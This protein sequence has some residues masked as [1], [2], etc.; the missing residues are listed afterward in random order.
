MT[1]APAQRYEFAPPPAPKR[2]S[3]WYASKIKP[4][5]AL[6][7]P[8]DA[9]RLTV[10]WVLAALSLC[11]LWFVFFATVMSSLQEAHNQHNAYA[12]FREQL[13]QL[14]PQTAP[15]G[16]IITPDSPVALINAP[17]IGLKDVVVI[18]GTAS[19]DLARGPGHRR[20]TPLPGQA[21]VAL[22]YG[23]ANLFGGAFGRVPQAKP[24]DLITVATGQ[25]ESKYKV[26]DVRH[27]GDPFPVSLADG[28]G[29]LT[30]VTSEGGTWLNGWMPKWPVYLDAKLQGQ[31]FPT[32]SGRLG[33][34]P[35][36]ENSMKGDIGALF[37]LVLWLPVLILA[38]IAAVWL[39]D[40]W[41]RWHTWL[42]GAPV[43]LAALWGVSE[44]AAQLLPNLM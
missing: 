8:P 41:G 22:I 20:D 11:T 6:G 37:P 25:G 18:E 23:R 44:T 28:D 42:A 15:L 10:A 34:V 31:A 7:G 12:A 16:G 32:P 17:S 2:A 13:T 14:A 29:Q 9:T 3:S 24:G 19:G 43:I 35:K 36:A 30:L 39:Q 4:R 38:A 5:I 21:G 33:S 26:E 40:R 27:V 1:T